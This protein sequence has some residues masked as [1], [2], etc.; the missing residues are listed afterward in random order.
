MGRR[1]CDEPGRRV[2]QGARDPGRDARG[3]APAHVAADPAA[4]FAVCAAVGG[5][6]GYGYADWTW[7]VRGAVDRL[8]GGVGLRRGRRDPRGLRAGD[9]L[10]FWR[11]EAVEPHGC[12]VCGRR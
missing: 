2:A 11:V 8:V 1:P 6:R 4:V 12:C 10:D 5:E 9:A 7:E 3:A